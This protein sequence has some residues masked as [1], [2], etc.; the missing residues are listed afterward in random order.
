MASAAVCARSG[1][2]RT[3]QVEGQ[4]AE[5]SYLAGLLQSLPAP[6]CLAVALLEPRGPFGTEVLHLWQLASTRKECSRL[7]LQLTEARQNRLV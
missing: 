7:A 5:D 3:C 2:T 6:Q 1:T 4:T